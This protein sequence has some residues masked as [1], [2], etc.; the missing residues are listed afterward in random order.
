M[1]RSNPYNYLNPPIDGDYMPIRGWTDLSELVDLARE[2][3]GFVKEEP[4]GSDGG[5]ILAPM[6]AWVGFTP[7]SFWCAAYQVW[8]WGRYFKSINKSSQFPSGR[9]PQVIKGIHALR[10]QFARLGPANSS[11]LWKGKDRCGTLEGYDPR[12]VWY[13]AEEVISGEVQIRPGDLVYW[14]AFQES[15]HSSRTFMFTKVYQGNWNF[16][17][18][19]GM[20]TGEVLHKDGKVSQY[21]TIEGNTHNRA[22]YGV[23]NQSLVS[24]KWHSINEP[25]KIAG[26]LRYIGD[27]DGRIFSPCPIDFDIGIA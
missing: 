2:D 13:R 5:P 11:R 10:Q 3:I 16:I 4:P 9:D 15:R 19:V 27:Y 20:C 14:G 18:H 6:W 25:D 23:A 24:D 22:R 1:P 21:E 26:F 17:G 7:G 8:V 12:W